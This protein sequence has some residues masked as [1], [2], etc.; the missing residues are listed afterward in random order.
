MDWAR[1]AALLPM[2]GWLTIWVVCYMAGEIT[3]K[4]FADSPGYKWYALSPLMY[5]LGCW[6]GWLPAML[7]RNE[8]A[9]MS[10][11]VAALAML[12]SVVIGIGV[13]GERIT[14]TQAVGMVFAAVAL[15]LLH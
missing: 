6:F 14:L 15:V 9:V 8:L 10:T 2:W 5:G 1:F 13:F 12:A 4:W 7:K 3:S 11:V